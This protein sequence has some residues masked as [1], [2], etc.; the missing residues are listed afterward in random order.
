MN[1]DH[2]WAVLA[3]LA[4]AAWGYWLF[5][6]RRDPEPAGE[7][8]IDVDFVG[9]QDLKWLLEVSG[10]LTNKSLVRHKYQDFQVVIRYLL[11]DD[12]I[13]D[14]GAKVN[15][16]LLCPRVIDERIDKQPR[17]F[18]N[19]EYINPRLTFRHSYVTF[20]PEKATFIWVQCKLRYPMHGR[21]LGWKKELQTKNAQRFFKVPGDKVGSVDSPPGARCNFE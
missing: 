21:W 7:L 8:Q 2:L 14:G 3:V 18:A 1:S 12:K 20:I 9:Q 5:R 13:E 10:T 6:V 17:F 4:S 15:Y 19:A 11:P 16:Q